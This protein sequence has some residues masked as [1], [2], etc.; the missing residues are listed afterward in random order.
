MHVKIMFQEVVRNVTIKAT[1]RLATVK[2]VTVEDSFGAVQA[3]M[4]D[5]V[6]TNT[7]TPIGRNVT[8]KNSLLNYDEFKKKMVFTINDSSSFVVRILV[9]LSYAITIFQCVKKTLR[10]KN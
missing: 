7:E 10:E 2:E 6:A 3:R 8:I 5:D 9:F 4:W 1:G